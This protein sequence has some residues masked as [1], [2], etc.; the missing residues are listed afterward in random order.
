MK[1]Y[2]NIMLQNKFFVGT[3]EIEDGKIISIKQKKEEYDFRGSVIPTFINM[4]THI[5]DFYYSEEPQGTLEEVVGPGGIKYR[6]LQNSK[7]VLRGMKDAINM[8]Q[9]CGISHFVDFREGGKG[10]VNLL[11]EASQG[12]KIKPII[13]GRGDL[14]DDADGVGLSSITDVEFNDATKL[15]EKAHKANKIFAIH[16]SENKR[17]DI[18]KILSLKPDFLVHMLKATDKDLKMV[19]Q[20]NIPVV[21]TPR[22]NAFWGSMPNIPK[23]KSLSLKV[24]LGTDNGMLSSPCMFREIE[25]AYR[26]S[27][28]QGEYGRISP[29]DIIRMATTVP[30]EILGIRDNVVGKGA[31]IVVFKKIITPYQIVT[32]ASC[33]DIRFVTRSVY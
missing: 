20:E 28:I 22:A 19:A 16:A 4:H 15:S 12:F 18:K 14:W 13:L 5:G 1:I 27:R 10:G 31:N 29:E 23:L 21:I 33:R 24:A 2:G 17:E 26:I 7:K 6:I 8:M 9:R 3:V 25:F 32:K 11:R 30:R